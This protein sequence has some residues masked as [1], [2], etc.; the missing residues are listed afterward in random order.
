VT[1][2]R[3]FAYPQVAIATDALFERELPL[4]TGTCLGA[5]LTVGGLAERRPV[6]LTRYS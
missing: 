5:A 1:S 6:K 2:T 4:T 3:V